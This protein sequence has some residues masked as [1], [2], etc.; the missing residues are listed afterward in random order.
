MPQTFGKKQK[1]KSKKLIAQV[2]TEGKAVTKFPVKLLYI[3]VETLDNHQATFAVPKKNFKSAVDRNRIKRQLREAYRLQKE[4]LITGSTI[5]FAL[6][7]LYLGKDKP[8]YAHLEKS[9]DILIKKILK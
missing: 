3:P 9:V 7:F 1:L 2:F 4:Q 6:L 5:K 8:N